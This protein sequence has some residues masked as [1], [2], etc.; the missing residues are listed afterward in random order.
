MAE[1][2]TVQQEARRGTTDILFDTNY[3]G[4]QGRNWVQ[5]GPV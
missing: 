5:T 1:K 4:L 3:Y 2:I